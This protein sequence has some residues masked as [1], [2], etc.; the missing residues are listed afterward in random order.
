M[1]TL[2]VA[3]ARSLHACSHAQLSKD[4]WER[5]N[6]PLARELRAGMPSW[7]VH[8]CSTAALWLSR[9][10]TR[11]RMR[12]VS[13]APRAVA[14]WS[15]PRRVWGHRERVGH[16]VRYTRQDFVESPRV[17]ASEDTFDR[18]YHED[19]EGSQPPPASARRPP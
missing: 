11:A 1:V 16:R 13:P 19:L 8:R 5:I 12:T 9:L 3:D 17:Y 6:Q 15:G 7:Q 4:T 18:L 2:A 14:S 10:R